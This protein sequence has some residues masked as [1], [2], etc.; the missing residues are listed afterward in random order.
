MKNVGSMPDFNSGLQTFTPDSPLL[1]S[2]SPTT[3]SPSSTSRRE[4]GRVEFVGLKIEM[5][6]GESEGRKS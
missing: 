3:N 4:R 2:S 6:E 1:L 5:V